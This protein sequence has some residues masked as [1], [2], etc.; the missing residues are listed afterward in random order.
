[1][2]RAFLKRNALLGEEK[3]PVQE[4]AL[5]KINL[6]RFIYSRRPIK[7]TVR[8]KGGGGTK[9][10]Y[11]GVSGIFVLEGELLVP[12]SSSPITKETVLLFMHP[13]ASSKL[14]VL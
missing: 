7:I 3:N 10:K 14:Q 5:A 4:N 12:S 13:A 2:S 6:F 9:D 8:E 11:G 1:M